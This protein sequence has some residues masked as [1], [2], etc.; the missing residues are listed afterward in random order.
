MVSGASPE[1]SRW[2]RRKEE[3]KKKIIAVAM[4]L[5]ERQG[6]DKTSMEQIAD[7]ADIAKG[8]LYNYFPAKEAIIS[9][10]IQRSVREREPKVQLLIE[11]LPDTRSRLIGLFDKASEWAVLHKD[12]MQKYTYY[13]FQNLPNSIKDQSQRSGFENT[14]AR[15]IGAG[16]EAGEIRPDMSDEVMARYLEV[17]HSMVVL[18]WLAEPDRFPLKK[19]L[20]AMVDLFIS[21]AK[22]E[23]TKT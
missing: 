2:E 22:K 23:I 1:G 8:T 11:S 14:L 16:Q 9:E 5:F 15:I 13:R 10:Y 19:S 4:D 7:E 17:L 20:V 3:T 6:F 21:G 12:I 18:S